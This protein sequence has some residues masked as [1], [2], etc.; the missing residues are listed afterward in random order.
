VLGAE[1]NKIVVSDKGAERD[2]S[3]ISIYEI[4]LYEV[5]VI[6]KK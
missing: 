4:S 5:P 6:E 2:S 1:I 3:S